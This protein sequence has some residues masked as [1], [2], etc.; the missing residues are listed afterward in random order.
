M[1]INNY[2]NHKK[3]NVVMNYLKIY[4]QLIE[5]R[6]TKTFIGYGERHHIIP[7]CMGGTNTKENIVRLKAREHFIAHLLLAKSH[8][9]PSLIFA[10]NMMMYCNKKKYTNRTYEWIKTEHSKLVSDLKKGKLLAPSHIKILSDNMKGEKNPNY[11]GVLHIGKKRS[12]DFRKK[13][14]EDNSGVKNS[15]YGKKGKLNPFYGKKHTEEVLN[16]L[17][18][19]GHGVSSAL[20]SDGL[21]SISH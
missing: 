13:Q 10:A 9:T 6:K 21:G 14:S 19:I 1:I 16:F 5:T 15:M 8:K 20:V 2:I 12:D 18:Y 11:K 17:A 4:N 3:G 7:K